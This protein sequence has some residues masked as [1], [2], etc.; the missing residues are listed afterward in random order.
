MAETTRGGDRE[1]LPSANQALA[2]LEQTTGKPVLI[3]EEPELKVLAT[4]SRAAPAQSSHLLRLKGGSDQVTDYL[5]AFECR[6]ALRDGPG[7]RAVVVEKRHARERVISEVEKMH[8]RLPLTK[9]RE[10][11]KFMYNG[12]IV[13]LRSMGPGMV[14]DRWIRQH[15]QDLR[16][17]QGRS[18]ESEINNNLG[19]LQPG[20]RDNFPAKIY[21]ASIAM[22]AAYAV[23]GGD[24]LGKPYLG[25]P[26]V[27]QGHG[28]IARCLISA[29]LGNG[30]G[31]HGRSDREII[32]A[33]AEA[34]GIS[35]WYDWSE[36]VA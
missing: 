28:E 36:L 16:E 25:V 27:S 20:S 9:A 14:V 5:I 29:A 22:N 35:S 11:G 17:A 34:L 30:E 32:D 4:I 19:V 15:C 2:E 6:M 13:Q 31:L 26:Y 33:W 23:F 18:I 8:R 21:D 24:L 3:V 10:L 1:F 7:S 12:L